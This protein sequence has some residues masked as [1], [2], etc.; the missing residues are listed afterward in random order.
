MY[1]DMKLLPS[2]TDLVGCLMGTITFTAPWMGNVQSCGFQCMKQCSSTRS[3]NGFYSTQSLHIISNHRKVQ[4]KTSQNSQVQK[5]S[6]HLN[7]KLK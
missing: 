6:A 2:H 7:S 4:L 3:K 5:Y 1:E